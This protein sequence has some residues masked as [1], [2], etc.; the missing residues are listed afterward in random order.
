MGT[1]RGSTLYR[2]L[3]PV[4]LLTLFL[5]PPASAD[6]TPGDTIDK[7]NWQ[8]VE[9]LVPP[10]VVTWVKQGKTVLHVGTLSYEPGDSF[11]DFVLKGYDRN[12]GRYALHDDH[13]IVE[14]ETGKPAEPF[15]G[16]PFPRVDLADPKAGEKIMYNHEYVRHCLGDARGEAFVLL[17]GSSGYERTVAWEFCQTAMVGNPKYAARANPGDLLKHQIVV[18]RSPYDLSGMAVMTWRFRAPNKP[19][20][21]FG[22][23]PAIRRVRRTSPANRS[24][25]MFGSDVANDD[26]GLYD[27][28]VAAMEWKLLRK[29]EALLPFAG[30]D[31]IPIEQ[32]GGGEWETTERIKPTTFGYEQEGW[33]GAKWAP[34]N[35]VWV[36]GPTYVIEM[37]PKDRYY[38]YGVQHIWIS[39][40]AHSPAF[41]VIW[42]RS[43][44]YWKTLVKARMVGESADRQMRLT[45]L[46]DT[47][48]VDERTNHATLGKVATP[49]IVFSY[50][51]NLDVDNFSLAGFQKYCK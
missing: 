34:L 21:C 18:V 22:Y 41:K 29:Q 38:N 12:A 40:R 1:M 11:P 14:A 20:L 25:A 4:Y 37:R 50:F 33:Q 36:K 46:G 32:N 17:V 44:S 26:A 6:V 49:E 8:K 9:G 48:Y 3:L 23:A 35:W 15:T 39:A 10:S 31:P 5:A 2:T 24:D 43:G 51:A 27:G 30:R 47:I 7:T 42:D 19:D 16:A 13:W 45:M 28:K